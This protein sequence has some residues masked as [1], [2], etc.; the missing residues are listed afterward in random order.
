M[1]FYV[2]VNFGS[3]VLASNEIFILKIQKILYTLYNIIDNLCTIVIIVNHV[4]KA[5]NFMLNAGIKYFLKTTMF[6]NL[7]Q[8]II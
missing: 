8:W 1:K 7:K 2:H 3:V 5:C 6:L 4:S